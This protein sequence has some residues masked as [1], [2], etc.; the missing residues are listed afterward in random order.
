VLRVVP[1]E[2]DG[3]YGSDNWRLDVKCAALAAGSC[4]EHLTSR[5]ACT[6]LY[7][8]SQGGVGTR[9]L[10]L[11]SRGRGRQACGFYF[12]DEPRSSRSSRSC[13]AV[14]AALPAGAT[15]PGTNGQIAFVRG[16]DLFTANPDG[17]H[18][19]QVPLLYPA[20]FFSVPAWSPDGGRLLISHTFRVDSEGECCLP[21]RPAIVNPDGSGFTLLTIP[22]GPFDMDCQVWSL[23]QTRLLC[24]PAA[25]NSFSA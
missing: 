7:E 10:L 3:R 5:C 4:G 13:F 18:V 24:D 21:F 15:V 8:Q 25:Q 14:L 2:L 9:S 23:D 6:S 16:G 17:T 22:D 1:I 19:N 20:D 12:A 11:I